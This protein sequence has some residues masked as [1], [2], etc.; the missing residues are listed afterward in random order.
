V[1]GGALAVE[2]DFYRGVVTPVMRIEMHKKKSGGINPPLHKP[3]IKAERSLNNYAPT[4]FTCCRA[5]ATSLTSGTTG[6]S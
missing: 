4:V 5:E 2:Y 1:G 6:M 3:E